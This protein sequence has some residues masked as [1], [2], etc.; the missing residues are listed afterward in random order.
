MIFSTFTRLKESHNYWPGHIAP[1]QLHRVSSWRWNLLCPSFRW[2]LRITRQNLLTANTYNFC[3]DGSRRHRLQSVSSSAD[4]PALA[5]GSEWRKSSADWR[6]MSVQCMRSLMCRC[7][8]NSK[9]SGR[10][11]YWRWQR[12]VGPVTS[13]AVL[14]A[15][16]Y[17]RHCRSPL[18]S[19][20]SKP[21]QNQETSILILRN[22][23]STVTQIIWRQRCFDKL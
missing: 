4:W 16:S 20:E 14:A 2:W 6:L 8:M 21:E 18:G 7:W 9:R 1:R 15:A 12:W 3:W 11:R 5:S 22:I 23:C 13:L 10:G 17:S 19:E